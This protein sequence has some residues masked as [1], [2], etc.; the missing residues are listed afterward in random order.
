MEQNTL[1]RVE[2]RGHVGQ[3]PRINQVGDL[4][5]ARF[6]IATN[7]TLKDR[8][9]VLREETTWHS[10]TAWSGKN[11]EDIEKLRKGCLVHVF[12]RIRTAKYK[13]VEGEERQF[14]EILATRLKV[15]DEDGGWP[16]QS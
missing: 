8:N 2:L 13:P 7:E 5:V 12:G 11:T 6:S 10:V 16:P 9:G 4:K 1:N 3:E 15:V 14:M